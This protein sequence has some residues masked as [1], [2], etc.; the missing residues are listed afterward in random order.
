MRRHGNPPRRVGCP[1]VPG[2]PGSPRTRFV[3]LRERFLELLRL[4]YSLWSTKIRRFMT[5]C[6]GCASCA[7]RSGVRR[8]VL[9]S[10]CLVLTVG[11]VRMCSGHSERRYPQSLSVTRTLGHCF[12]AGRGRTEP[13]DASVSD[14]MPRFALALPPSVQWTCLDVR[15]SVGDPLPVDPFCHPRVAPFCARRAALTPAAPRLCP[16]TA[17]VFAAAVLRSV[18]RVRTAVH[19]PAAARRAS[20]LHE[21]PTVWSC[22][23]RGAL[24]RRDAAQAAVPHDELVPTRWGGA[25]LA[26]VDALRTAHPAMRHVP[27]EVRGSTGLS[28]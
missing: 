11:D 28:D 16:R 21:A 1:A 17:A 22:R 9:R 6:A 24:P 26:R 12:Q 19:R 2:C 23:R 15:R 27:R 8:R 5:P 3:T 25:S 4:G 10:R 20:S 7:R 13:A 18:H 14:P